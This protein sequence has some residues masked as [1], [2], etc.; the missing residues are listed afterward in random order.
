MTWGLLS[1]LAYCVWGL[2][3]CQT[4]VTQQRLVRWGAPL[5]PG[6]PGRL[7]APGPTRKLPERGIPRPGRLR[8][9]L[10][11]T[12]RPR[13]GEGAVTF[14][15][16]DGW[17]LYQGAIWS[18]RPCRVCTC[19]AGGALCEDIECL[20]LSCEKTQRPRGQC[21]PVCV[22]DHR[23]G[24]SAR[25]GLGGAPSGGRDRVPANGKVAGRRPKAR[26][27][28][29]LREAARRP[30]RPA[31]GRK[32]PEEGP[33]AR[34][35][36]GS[37]RRPG[38][39]GARTREAA[40]L[41]PVAVSRGSGGEPEVGLQAVGRAEGEVGP[42]RPEVGLRKPELGLKRPE[43][44]PTNPELR[45]K[46]PDLG[47]KKPELSLKEVGVG[48][49]KEG[50]NSPEV[51]VKIPEAG[52]KEPET[53]LKEPDVGIEKVG[54]W[55]PEFGLKEVGIKSPEVSLKKVGLKSPD[56]GLKKPKVGLKKQVVGLKEVGLKSLEV[57]LKKPEVGLKKPE[58]GL[59]KPVVGLKK[60]S[61]KSPEVGLKKPEVGLKKPVVGL[62][63]P[64]VGLKKPEVGLKKPEVSLKEV[65]LKSTEVGQKKP[66]V[67]LKQVGLKSP[68]VGQKKPEIGLKKPDVGLKQVGQK[69]P[70]VG[71]KE[72]GLKSPEVGLKKLEAHL[73]KTEVGLKTVGLNK[74]DASL[75]KGGL[76]KPEV[77]LEN[78]EVGL[79]KV[80]LK[81]LE[82]GDQGLKQGQGVK[83][84]N[85]G[86]KKANVDPKVPKMGDKQ[87]VVH[88]KPARGRGSAREQGPGPS[89]EQRAQRKPGAG[90][91]E[92]VKGQTKGRKSPGARKDGKENQ[93][94]ASARNG[95]GVSVP[96]PQELLPPPESE[97][98]APS[99]PVGCIL[100]EN[101]IACPAAKLTEIPKL[102]DPG[103]QTLYLADNGI[104][105]VSASDF[106][107]LPNLQWLDLSRNRIAGDSL[108]SD[109][110]RN[111]TRLR[112]LNL[113]G[114]R[115][116]RV[117]HLPG[118]LRE[119]KLNDNRLRRLDRRSFRGL[120]QLLTL[121]LE[122]NNLN[123]GNVHPGALR[124]LKSL[125][126]L[127][128]GRNRFRALPSGLPSTLKEAGDV[129]SLP[130]PA[131][132][133]PVF[134]AH[135]NAAAP[136]PPQPDREDSRLRV[137][138]PGP[139]PGIP[140]PLLQPAAAHRD[141]RSLLPGPGR[142][143]AG[144]AAGSQ[145][146]G[147]YPS[148][149]AAAPRPAGPAAQSQPHLVCSIRLSV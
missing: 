108:D 80:D 74:P 135:G 139:R 118:S 33:G 133:R 31:R 4:A 7:P 90:R 91:A 72:V 50:L 147:G 44:G 138:P 129:G 64:E 125:V 17:L 127:R 77:E 142:F 76:N 30:S 15:Q 122:G 46:E 34:G 52:L 112:R 132:A 93:A 117:P 110:F 148:R 55:S 73:K 95:T 83:K 53:G 82:A 99:L 92:V 126:Y 45:P 113:D 96:F 18:P 37:P 2:V 84:P 26:G 94:G 100:A 61:L 79:K 32:A 128:L 62:K 58:V 68:E 21:C 143:P 81:T 137:R 103:L 130:Q 140:A 85:R 1:V 124:S 40:L 12:P 16:V 39:A 10:G 87:Q 13:P 69:K 60:V 25:P 19:E 71:L 54:L 11:A 144:A 106:S 6:L 78:P 109:A 111:L 47:P 136:A 98:G 20:A 149:T 28:A 43:V 114:N 49:K 56:M 36:R 48:L 42:R 38:P 24:T 119:L 89:K 116:S 70:V 57:G 134:P 66:E 141:P 22:P 131:G 146:A 120:H 121:G 9:T 97:T 23:Q 51:S 145:P 115:I 88:G 75:R 8:E 35:K 27:D 102:V 5:S 123:D 3:Q 65:G 107:G 86:R 101:A 104:R 29:R 41:R 67:G 63:S 14:C 105:S 59:K